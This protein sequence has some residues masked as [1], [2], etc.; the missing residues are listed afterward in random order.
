MTTSFWSWRCRGA[1]RDPRAARR[2]VFGDPGHYTRNRFSRKCVRGPASGFSAGVAAEQLEAFKQVGAQTPCDC[3]RLAL[4]ALR[5]DCAVCGRGMWRILLAASC[6][7]SRP[8]GGGWRVLAEGEGLA[9]RIA[10]PE[11]KRHGGL[12]AADVR[13]SPCQ[14]HP[15]AGSSTHGATQ[16][17]DQRRPGASDGARTTGA[18]LLARLASGARCS[19][20]PAALHAQGQGVRGEVRRGWLF[21]GPSDNRQCGVRVRLAVA[22]R[23]HPGGQDEACTWSWPAGA[24]A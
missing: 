23:F 12:D 7:T 5:A 6:P 20:T 9:G 3:A 15:L 21:A 10:S 14:G 18:G 24:A 2:R 19:A 4:R 22:A 1:P 13:S 11:Q 8:C 17:P 16:W